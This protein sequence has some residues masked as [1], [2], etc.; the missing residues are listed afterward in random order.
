MRIDH[1]FRSYRSYIMFWFWKI[2]AVLYKKAGTCFNY[3]SL[4]RQI[5]ATFCILYYLRLEKLYLHCALNLSLWKKCPNQ[6]YMFFNESAA[7]WRL[8]AKISSRFVKL[9]KNKYVFQKWIQKTSH[10][11]DVSINKAVVR[12]CSMKKVLE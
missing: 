7:F 8:F 9:T 11:L 10:W 6:I 12:R 5:I 1:A 2:D 3:L 4:R